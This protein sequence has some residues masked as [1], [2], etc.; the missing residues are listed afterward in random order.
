MAWAVWSQF[1]SIPTGEV[2]NH[3]SLS[4]RERMNDCS[5]NFQQ[6]YDCKNTIVI[7]TDRMTFLNMIGRI[8]IVVLPPLLLI[9]ALNFAGRRRDDDD[10]AGGSGGSDEWS[11][12]THYRRRYHRRT[13]SRHD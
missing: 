12:P 13:S 7:E 3:S 9:G 11:S 2:E 4:V 6:R 1:L 8:V 10:I 5:G